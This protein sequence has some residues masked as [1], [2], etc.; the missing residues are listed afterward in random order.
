MKYQ[1]S[2]A[3]KYIEVEIYVKEEEN[4]AIEVLDKKSDDCI[5]EKAKFLLPGWNLLNQI[6]SFASSFDG[7]ITR[8]N[9]GLLRELRFRNCLKEWSIGELEFNEDKT[10]LSD[11]C[12]QE[13]TGENGVNPKI[14]DAF[15]EKFG[16]K[17]Y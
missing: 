15:L 4:E 14:I 7:G 3:Q 17:L 11:K 16:E 5:V 12:Y 1:I 13:I 10:Q 9:T 6:L 2:E 8:I